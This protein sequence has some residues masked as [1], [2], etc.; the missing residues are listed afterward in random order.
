MPV[1]RLSTSWQEI[2][3]FGLGHLEWLV[4]HAEASGQRIV[5]T[6]GMNALG[7]PEFYL[8]DARAVRAIDSVHPLILTTFAHFDEAL[9][10][11]SSRHQSDW[12]RRLG[13]D[14]PAEREAL[15][16]LRK[17]DILGVDVYHLWVTEAQAEPWAAHRRTH[18]APRSVGPDD[19]TRLLDALRGLR[20]NV[21]LLWGSE[22]WLRR[23]ENGDPRWVASVSR[24]LRA[25][26]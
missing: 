18:G 7:W 5:L 12:K 23:E 17:G 24:E 13:L 10:R 22:Y 4:K 8:P 2:D 11:S 26:V 3:R 21:V 1:V 9:D 6:V 20:V 16:I 15:A 14:I 25:L 19:V